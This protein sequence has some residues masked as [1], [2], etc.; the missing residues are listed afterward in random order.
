[1]SFQEFYGL[2]PDKLRPSTLAEI[3]ERAYRSPDV[4]RARAERKERLA[5]ECIAQS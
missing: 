4:A 1:M 5:S 3:P 2:A